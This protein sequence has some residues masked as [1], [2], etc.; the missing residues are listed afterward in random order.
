MSLSTRA[1]LTPDLRARLAH[2]PELGGGN[3]LVRAMQVNPHPEAPFIHAIRPTPGIA[4]QPQAEF[5]LLDLDRLAQSWSVWYLGRGV[6]PRDRVS[7]F[8]A[9]TF[10]YWVHFYALA[11]IGAIGVLINSKAPRSTAAHLCRQT[12]PVGLFVGREQLDRLGDEP[13]TFETLKWIQLAEDLPAPAVG[14]LSDRDRFRHNPEDPVS[15]LHSSGTTG[16]PKPVIQTHASSVAGPRYRLLTVTEPAEPLFMTAQPQSHL[17]A[18]VY[19]TYSILGGVPIAPLFDPSGA[20]L[21]EA[22]REHRPRTVMAFSHAFA[23]LARCPV[24]EGAMDSVDNWISMGDAIHD[25]HIR[26]VLSRRDTRLPTPTF[27]DRFGNTELGWGVVAQTRTLSS[28]RCDRRVGKPDPIAEVAVLRADGTRA[29]VGEVGLFGAK[30]PTITAGYWNDSETTYRS[31]LGGFWLTGDY[32]YCD[33][34]GYFH[35]VDRAAD[36]IETAHGTGYSVAMEE[37][38]INEVAGVLDCAVIAGRLH[39]QVTPVAVVVGDEFRRDPRALFDA[40]NAVLRSAGHPPLGMLEL[41]R[42]EADYPVGVTG[43]VLK[44][45]LREKYSA[46]S[47][48]VRE[49]DGKALCAPFE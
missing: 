16:R 42:S 2:D 43:K 48:Y 8:I 41:A 24:E 36:A 23:E 5:S 47:L 34:D 18:I 6:R 39:G 28:Q 15:L 49:P 26:N 33:V 27:Y 37:V 45:E 32:V 21:A 3:I 30:G 40:V 14:V 17:G 20:E 10:A 22:V 11:Q 44:R 12:A 9:D 31:R 4:G 13:S 7:V 38:I 25:A 46:L 35:L 29:D 1:M 19:T